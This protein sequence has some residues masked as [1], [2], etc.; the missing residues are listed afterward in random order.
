MNSVCSTLLLLLC[1]QSLQIQGEPTNIK[2]LEINCSTN[3]ADLFPEA[4]QIKF[5]NEQNEPIIAVFKRS[6]LSKRS[7]SSSSDIYVLDPI[8]NQPR[9]AK[10]Q[11]EKV[12]KN[13][14]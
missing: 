2:N 8:S 9:L 1:I 10:I 11:I 4:C 12:R 7:A 6:L 5:Y 14:L 13:I 3:E